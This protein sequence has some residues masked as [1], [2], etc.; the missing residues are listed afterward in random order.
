MSLKSLNNNLND[1]DTVHSYLET[2]DKLFQSKKYGNVNVLE[3]GIYQGGSIKLWKD[4]FINGHIY[5]VEINGLDTILDNSIKHDDRITLYTNTNAYDDNFLKSKLDNI[6]FDFLIDDG[7]HT[8][9]SMIFYLTNYVHLLKA[10]G[11]LIIED[12]QDYSWIEV[13]KNNTPTEFQQYI[14]VIDIRHIKGRY[15]DLL[16]IIDKSGVL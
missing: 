8:L 12:V 6:K 16:F 9:E 3:I 2:Y 10:D 1:K 11:V 13:L 4:Y 15:D 14:K 5:G 7:P